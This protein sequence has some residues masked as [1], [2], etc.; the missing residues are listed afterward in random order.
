MNSKLV[1]L[2]TFLPNGDPDVTS[3]IPMVDGGTE[4][5]ISIFKRLG[6]LTSVT[7]VQRARAGDISLYNLL[8]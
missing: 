1:S 3:I 2:V 7:G 4:V 6:H 5:S 8:L